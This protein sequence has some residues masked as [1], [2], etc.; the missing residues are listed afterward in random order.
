[1]PPADSRIHNAHIS[2]QTLQMFLEDCKERILN[3]SAVS[4]IPRLT[5]EERTRN[6]DLRG[7]FKLLI[8]LPAVA[9]LH[10]S[11]HPFLRQSCP[12]TAIEENLE[13]TKFDKKRRKPSRTF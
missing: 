11:Y 1:M 8:P 5:P 6:S 2:L 13:L 10:L 4:S 3:L 7:L 9:M 12:L